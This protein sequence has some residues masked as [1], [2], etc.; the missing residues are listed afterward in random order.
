MTILTLTGCL[1]DPGLGAAGP[2]HYCFDLRRTVRTVFLLSPTPCDKWLTRN[3]C[4]QVTSDFQFARFGE[5]SFGCDR[6]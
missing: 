5:E 1:D 2:W 3:V 4:P 6:I